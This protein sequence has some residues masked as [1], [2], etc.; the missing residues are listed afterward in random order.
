[1]YVGMVNDPKNICDRNVTLM[2]TNRRYTGPADIKQL[3][4]I[5]SNNWWSQYWL[6]G[7]DRKINL[8]NSYT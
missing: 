7:L 4:T 8:N 6:K 2:K 3:S 1:M 5:F